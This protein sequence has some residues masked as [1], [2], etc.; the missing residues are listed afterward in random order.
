MLV[1]TQGGMLM[2]RWAND[3]IAD[4]H[5]AGI[6]GDETEQLALR[7]RVLRYAQQGRMGWREVDG[8]DGR[9]RYN[10]WKYYRLPPNCMKAL[11]W[12][13]VLEGAKLFFVWSYAPPRR[14]ELDLDATSSALREPLQ[15]EVHWM[16][17]A[18]R[19]GKANRQLEELAEA[20]REIR[21]FERLIVRM[22]KS[23]DSPITC[24]QRGVHHRAFSLPGIDGGVVVIH[25][26]NVG[27]WP[28]GSRHMFRDDDLIAI[29]DDGNLLGY[30]PF[31]EPLPVRLSLKGPAAHRATVFDVLSGRPLSPD[32]KGMIT[33]AVLPGSAALIYVGRN[34][35]VGKVRALLE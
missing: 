29:D 15:H 32:P 22:R 19:P 11:A 21:P 35:D 1:V 27:Q 23:P 10:F 3:M 4:P 28:H 18:G 34:D 31:D 30:V 24:D 7:A 13:S 17:L 2:P 26:A 33:A 12:T 9:P 14:S 8:P 25:N 20:A 16:T 6:P 5:G